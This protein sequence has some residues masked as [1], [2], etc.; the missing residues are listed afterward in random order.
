MVRVIID[1]GHGG[2]DTVGKS[3]AYGVQGQGI[4]EKDVTLD[5]AR[6]IADRLGNHVALT[7]SDDRNISLGARAATAMRENAEVF[8]SI[9]A[10]D[11]PGHETWIHPNSASNSQALATQIQTSLNGLAGDSGGVP[12]SGLMAVLDP[13]SVGPS[14]AA[15]LVEIGGMIGN[16]GSQLAAA[17]VRDAIAKAVA[18]GVNAHLQ[19]RLGGRFGA[20]P[21]PD[22]YIVPDPSSYRGQGLSDFARIWLSWFERTARWR[23]GVPHDAYPYFPHSAICELELSGAGFSGFGTGFYIGPNKILT[24]GHNFMSAGMQTSEVTVRPGKS[25][26]QS[27]FPHKKFTVNGPSLVHPNWAASED[28]DF[29]LA[30]LSTP[31]LSAPNNE[32]FQLPNM[33]PA[34]TEQMVVCGYGKF[35]GDSVASAD[36]GQYMDGGTI[37]HATAEQYHFPIQAIPGHSGSPMFW[38]EMVV[39]ILTGPRMLGAT[40]ISDYE[41]RGVRL[42]PEKN[43]WINSR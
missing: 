30:V 31:G 33:T 2:N 20:R 21:S 23:S 19:N 22:P 18:S 29:D 13:P 34:S 16:N 26:V 43:D 27:I 28:D 37:T 24:C 9:H 39:A 12:Q 42:T 7:R 10:A 32:Y 25:P 17:E 14:V 15:C 35:Q 40:T 38:D 8:V 4:H 6:R 11:H 3:S 41:N 1:A 5:I 36:E